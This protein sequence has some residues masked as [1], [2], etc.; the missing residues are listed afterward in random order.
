MLSTFLFSVYLPFIAFLLKGSNPFHL[1]HRLCQD[2]LD[3]HYRNPIFQN[4]I[5]DLLCSPKILSEEI[6][7]D[8]IHIPV[9]IKVEEAGDGEAVGSQ[10]VVQHIR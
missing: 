9:V 1:H 3:N 4:S 7:I 8:K 10:V 5:A 2:Q 6:K